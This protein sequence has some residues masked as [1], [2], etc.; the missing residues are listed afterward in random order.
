MHVLKSE[1]L[2]FLWV[3]ARS[4]RT[5]H[6]IAYSKWPSKVKYSILKCQSCE[7]AETFHA[8][9]IQTPRRKQK[10]KITYRRWILTVE[11]W[12]N[13]KRKISAG[14][15]I[16]SPAPSRFSI[17]NFHSNTCCY[18]SIFKLNSS[19][20][21][22]YEA[23]FSSGWHNET[24]EFF[25]T[26]L[27]LITL[28]LSLFSVNRKMKKIASKFPIFNLYVNLLNLKLFSCIMKI[29]CLIWG[30]KSLLTSINS[31]L[32]FEFAFNVMYICKL[33]LSSK[34]RCLDISVL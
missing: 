11:L 22:P 2:Y 16:F 24:T 27:M 3:L 26:M 34:D 15:V 18:H 14:G 33:W 23:N 28:I 9:R 25:S 5:S 30:K 12:N 29:T 4:P 10:W 13:S 6:A 8:W 31:N 19:Q 17:H 32:R 7:Q 20:Q 21:L 1:Q